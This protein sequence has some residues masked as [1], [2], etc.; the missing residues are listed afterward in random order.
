MS[1]RNGLV[2][3]VLTVVALLFLHT[4]TAMA[5]MPEPAAL[6]RLRQ[7]AA[8]HPDDPD[9]AWALARELADGGDPDAALG[10]LRRFRE[11]WPDRRP[12]AARILGRLLHET[13]R[14]EE[15]VE[16]FDGHT[17]HSQAVVGDHHD[18]VALKSIPGSIAPKL[19]AEVAG[20]GNLRNLP[21][22]WRHKPQRIALAPGIRKPQRESS[23]GHPANISKPE[24]P[25]AQEITPNDKVIGNTYDCHGLHEVGGECD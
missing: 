12:E 7:V 10:A 18:F 5:E 25:G 6:E 9:L 8:A 20:L 3:P 11:R 2:L 13:G 16:V 22:R 1:R 17:F 19:G 24:Y 15:A 14:D 23:F 21:A 4:V